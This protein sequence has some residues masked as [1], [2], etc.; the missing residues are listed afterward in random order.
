MK[1]LFIPLFIFIAFSSYSQPAL[2]LAPR[3]Q[4]YYNIHQII[5]PDSSTATCFS[6]S[7]QGKQYIVTAKHVFPNKKSGDTVAFKINIGN[8]VKSFRLPVFFHK[9]ESV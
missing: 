9:I 2:P 8:E 6:Q 5:P 7:Y 1:T 4:E 3:S